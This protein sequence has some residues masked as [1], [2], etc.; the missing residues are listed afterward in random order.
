MW[1]NGHGEPL[2]D[3][4]TEEALEWEAIYCRSYYEPETIKQ[5]VELWNGARLDGIKAFLDNFERALDGGAPLAYTVDR[6]LEINS[7]DPVT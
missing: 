3:A 6:P 7:V 1:V 2:S 4:A 5:L